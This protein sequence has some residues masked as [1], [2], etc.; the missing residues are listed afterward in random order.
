ML[1]VYFSLYH[2]LRSSVKKVKLTKNLIFLQIL[3][4]TTGVT[5]IVILKNIIIQF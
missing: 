4:T 2:M 1:S 5:E 3:F